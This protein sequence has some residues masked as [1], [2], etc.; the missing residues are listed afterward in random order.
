MAKQHDHDHL[1]SYT[2]HEDHINLKY[3]EDDD[4]LEALSA[5]GVKLFH[6]NRSTNQRTSDE[7]ISSSPRR[8]YEQSN[9][10]RNCNVF[11]ISRS[12]SRSPKGTRSSSFLD[13]DYRQRDQSKYRGERQARSLSPENFRL[14][15]RARG[16]NPRGRRG[17]PRRPLPARDA[18]S[19][20]SRSRPIRQSPTYLKP[21]VSGHPSV[22]RMPLTAVV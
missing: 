1:D 12:R 9:L 4:D 22:R 21:D 15:D 2:N 10:G 17:A 20:D 19:V 18:R 3:D 16:W 8:R 7:T 11:N 6:R 5:Q 13:G 14:S